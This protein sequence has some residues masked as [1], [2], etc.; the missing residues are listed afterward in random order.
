MNGSSIVAD[1]SLLVNFFNGAELARE[2]L[3]ARTIWYATIT[4]IELLCYPELSKDETALIE[5]F[6]GQCIQQDLTQP[7]INESINIRKKYRLKVPDAI[8]A[9]TAITCNLP[10]I[11]M[12]SDFDQVK[13]LDVLIA[14]I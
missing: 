9:A 10:L 13:N 12:D 5:S 7:V 3:E 4:E 11:T 14:E 2:I 1:T 6:L 8:I